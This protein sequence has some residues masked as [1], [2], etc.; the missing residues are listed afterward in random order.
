MKLSVIICTFMRV[1]SLELIL[2]SIDKQNRLPDQV[3][4]VD[5]SFNDSCKK[6]VENSNYSFVY[7]YTLVGEEFRGLTLQRNFGISKVDS[8]MDLVS[9]LDDDLVLKADYFEKIVSTFQKYESAIGVGGIDL[10]E[11]TFFETDKKSPSFFYY[12]LDGWFIK[13]SLRNLVRKSFGL[14]SNKQPFVVPPYGHGRSVLPPN[15]KVYAVE[16]FMGGIATYRLS[17]FKEIS[18]SEYFQGYGLYEDFDFCVRALKFGKLYINTAAQVWHYHDDS[19]R[20]NFFK[21]GKMVVRNGWFVW[22]LRFTNISAINVFKWHMITLLL[23]NL[24]LVNSIL[25][26]NRKKAFLDYCG[27]MVGWVSLFF[28]SPKIVR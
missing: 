9:F 20:P 24:R 19:G 6:L 23:A 4:I 15:G 22:K 5:S 26:P 28:D 2:D 3:I 14:M 18:F 13:E 7:S 1:E 27:R 8:S 17:L 25:G 11:N 16:H 12:E 10:V 21:Y